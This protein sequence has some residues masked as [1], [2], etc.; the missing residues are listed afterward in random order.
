M[1]RYLENVIF[2]AAGVKLWWKR[3]KGLERYER[4]KHDQPKQVFRGWW[5]IS[6]EKL[7]GL[8]KKVFIFIDYAFDEKCKNESFLYFM[9][10][11]PSIQFNWYKYKNQI[12]TFLNLQNRCLALKHCIEVVSLQIRTILSC[13]LSLMFYT[14]VFFWRFKEVT[15]DQWGLGTPHGCQK[16]LIVL[17]ALHRAGPS[18]V[19]ILNT[20][21]GWW[22]GCFFFGA[23]CQQGSPSQPFLQ[24]SSHLL[25]AFCNTFSF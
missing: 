18:Q 22:L 13:C 3:L 24:H 15:V 8:H 2:F 4:Y 23:C 11:F 14:C 12:K 10:S 20:L 21:F 1:Q 16:T 6:D 17:L 9:N 5:E 25:K 19:E 7:L